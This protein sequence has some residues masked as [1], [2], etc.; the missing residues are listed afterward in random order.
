MNKI[1]NIIK[2]DKI[3]NNNDIYKTDEYNNIKKFSIVSLGKMN[4]TLHNNYLNSIFSKYTMLYSHY[5]ANKTVVIVGPASSI[6]NKMNGHIIDEFDI[7][8]RLNKAL[9]LSKRM[10]KYTG[11]KTDIVYNSLNTTSHPGENNLNT[12]MYKKCGVKFVCSPYPNYS[13]FKKDIDNYVSKYKF[14]IPFRCTDK[15]MYLNFKNSINTRPYTGTCAIWDILNFPIKMLYITGI[16]FYNTP[17]YNQYR[18]IKKSQ[19]KT[20]RHNN[21]HSA[22]PQMEY[23]LYKSLTDN[24]VVLDDTLEKLLYNNYIKIYKYLINININVIFNKQF[25]NKIIHLLISTNNIV[26]ISNKNINKYSNYDIIFNMID[27]NTIIISKKNNIIDTL[28]L[29]K[30]INKQ[31]IKFIN[32]IINLIDLKKINNDL[33]IIFI[34]ISIYNKNIYYNNLNINIKKRYKEFLIL[35]Y[36]NKN[37]ILK[38]I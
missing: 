16:D 23:L 19:L 28:Y 13:V 6:K 31:F 7:V 18:R 11:S 24:R 36:L 1:Y 8:I 12:K 10:I 5:L 2:K 14:D 32:K 33:L 37:D 25:N 4:I 34:L 9:P 38:V 15:K 29:N 27:D 21:I 17:Y 3:I 20:L 22:F 26:F 35:S 30:H